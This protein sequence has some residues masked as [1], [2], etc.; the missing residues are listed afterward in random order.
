MVIASDPVSP[1]NNNSPKIIGAAESASTVKLYT[2]A[3]CTGA[4]VAT[5]SAAAFASPGIA[6]S[7]PDN[8]TTTFRATAT[9]ASNNTSACSPTSIAY[10]E[11]TPS[12]GGGDTTPPETTITGG[13]PRKTKKRTATFTFSSNEPGAFQCKLDSGAFALCAS[14]DVLTGLKKGVHT[15]S[16]RAVDAS[17]NVDGS[18]A[19]QTW[20]I[21]KKRRHHHH[22]HH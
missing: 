13:P 18:P 17:L 1:A 21:K 22:H 7:V 16:V 8:S 5:G 12:G 6:V 2:D 20:K 11:V 14:P 3:S 19:T 9:D 15:F 10:T 4:V